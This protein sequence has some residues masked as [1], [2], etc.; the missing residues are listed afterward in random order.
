MILS[1]AL[2]NFVPF[3]MSMQDKNSWFAKWFDSKYYHLLYNHRDYSEAERFIQNLFDF[4]QL[5]KSTTNVLDLACGKGRHAIQ[6]HQLGFHVV[7]VDLSEQSIQYAKNYETKGLSFEVGDMRSLR[8]KQE[9][10]LVLNLFTSFGYFKEEGENQKAIEAMAESLKPDGLLVLDYLNVALIQK[11]LP[12]RETIQK[13]EIKFQIKKEIKS[14]FIV[15]EIAFKVDGKEQIHYEF[16]KLINLNRF[17]QYL[18]AAGLTIKHI[19]GDYNLGK[20]DSALSDRLIII[21]QKQA[22]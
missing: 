13:G 12:S 21:A 19:F 17:K 15:K 8:F 10:N 18:A 5:P 4:I 3:K 9:F 14:N 20:F 6:V 22:T 7:G 1:F 2:S 11:A 16:V